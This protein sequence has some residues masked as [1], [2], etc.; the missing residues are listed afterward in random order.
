MHFRF[1]PS[2]LLVAVAHFILVRRKHMLSINVLWKDPDL[3]RCC[4]Q[5][6]GERFTG[7]TN[8]YLTSDCF[9]KL[10]DAISGFPKSAQDEREW[11]THN[12]NSF[13][14]SLRCV[15]GSGHGI[16]VVDLADH[17]DTQQ[18]ASIRFPVT[19]GE[20]DEFEKALRTMSATEEG[21]A[22]LGSDA[23]ISV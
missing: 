10:A 14:L 11:D 7:A 3:M 5:A 12:Y 20:I 23:K 8:I 1:E 13:R 16:A 17:E 21:S 22:A 15:D 18:S 4:V 19:A 2:A 9:Q 6:S